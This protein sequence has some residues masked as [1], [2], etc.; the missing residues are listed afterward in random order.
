MTLTIT[1]RGR[2][3]YYIQQYAKNLAL[4]RAGKRELVEMCFRDE[5]TDEDVIDYIEARLAYWMHKLLTDGE[6]P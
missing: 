6:R 3:K 1:E 4:M 5:E 2:A